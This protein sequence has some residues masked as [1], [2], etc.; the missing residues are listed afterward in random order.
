MS[1][2]TDEEPTPVR[3]GPPS[4]RIND[5]NDDDVDSL[6]QRTVFHISVLPTAKTQSS[7][8]NTDLH[9]ILA[10]MIDHDEA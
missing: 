2:M 5:D 1:F 10:A 9:G 3:T 7:F 4:A 8:A 6:L